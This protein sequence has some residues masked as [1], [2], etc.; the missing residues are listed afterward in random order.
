MTPHAQISHFSLYFFL[1][2]SGAI[3]SIVPSV[4]LK[5]PP[6]LI[7]LENPKSIIFKTV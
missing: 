4:F 3:Y 2:I 6:L 5:V 1:N 7:F